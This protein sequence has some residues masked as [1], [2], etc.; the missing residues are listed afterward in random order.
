MSSKVIGSDSDF[1]S[2]MVYEAVNLIK[3]PD[4]K[5]GFTYPIKAINILKAHGKSAR[6][7]ALISGYA[8][9]CT[10]ASHGN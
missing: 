6:E 2:N 10:V 1:F 9:N 5:G 3:I 4:A 7:S 8:L